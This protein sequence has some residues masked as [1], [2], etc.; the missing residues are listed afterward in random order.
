VGTAQQRVAGHLRAGV[1]RDLGSLRF[2]PFVVSLFSFTAF[3]VFCYWLHERDKQLM[4]ARATA[5]T[6]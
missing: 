2:P 3:F 1:L 4:A 6:A 5:A